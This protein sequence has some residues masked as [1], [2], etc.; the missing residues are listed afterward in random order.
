MKAAAE[1][2]EGLQSINISK[3]KKACANCIWYRQYYLKNV[4]NVAMFLPSD[5]GQCMQNGRTRSALSRPC[6]KFITQL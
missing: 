1:K 4:G 2:N 3:C 5:S 6:N